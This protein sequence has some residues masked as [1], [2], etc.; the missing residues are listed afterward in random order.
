MPTAIATYEDDRGDDGLS[1]DVFID[2]RCTDRG[3]R[4]FFC[5]V[6]GAGEPPSG[7]EFEVTGVYAVEMRRVGNGPAREVIGAAITDEAVLAWVNSEATYDAMLD[8]YRRGDD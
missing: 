1:M 2:F 4:G 8:A 7:P 5:H 6:T 3:C